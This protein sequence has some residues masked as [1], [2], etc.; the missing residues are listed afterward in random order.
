MKYVVPGYARLLFEERIMLAV[1]TRSLF[2]AK[3]LKRR[4]VRWYQNTRSSMYSY[5]LKAK[6]GKF[7]LNHYY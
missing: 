1:V 4:E 5:R 6:T 7:Y 2:P 3:E